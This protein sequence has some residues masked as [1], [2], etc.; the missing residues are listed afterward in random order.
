MADSTLVALEGLLVR[1]K[2]YTA[3]TNIVSTRIYSNVPQQATF[4]YT[5]IELESSDWSQND[6]ANLQHTVRVHGYS[7]I[8]SPTEVMRISEQVYNALNRQ[9]DNISLDTGTVV[10]LQLNGVKTTFKEPDGITWHS[11][12]EFNLII[13]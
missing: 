5:L 8:S 12:I 9:E 11:V 10:L 2:A 1:L 6:D 4:P 3:L 13:D 7:R